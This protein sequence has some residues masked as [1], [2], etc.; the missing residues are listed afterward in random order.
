[1]GGPSR[2]G[3]LASFQPTIAQAAPVTARLD[4][5]GRRSC[6]PSPS[7]APRM[8]DRMAELMFQQKIT[9]MRQRRTA[10]LILELDLTE[11]LAE[12]P[13][14]DPVS[15]L[16]TM[17][18]APLAGGLGGGAPAPPHGRGEGRGGQPR[19]RATAPSPR[20]PPPAAAPPP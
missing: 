2:F 5:H 16:L 14:S 12:E 4:G 9:R 18:R 6:Q 8:V 11:G 3:R 20:P 7:P 1:G 10:P 13:P 15:A 19:G 17:R